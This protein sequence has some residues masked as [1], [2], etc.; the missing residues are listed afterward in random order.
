LTAVAAISQFVDYAAQECK[1]RRVDTFSEADRLTRP[2]LV[3]RL[4][5]DLMRIFSAACPAGR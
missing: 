2:P 1:H 5:V 3:R 4:Y